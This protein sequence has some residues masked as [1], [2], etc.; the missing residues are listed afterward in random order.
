MKTNSSGNF[1]MCL[2]IWTGKGLQ[3]YYQFDN[4]KWF[5]DCMNDFI[6]KAVFYSGLYEEGGL[7]SFSRDFIGEGIS[8]IQ[9]I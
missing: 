2:K 4:F 1:Q 3:I 5:V 7:Q 6:L 8:Q 9:K